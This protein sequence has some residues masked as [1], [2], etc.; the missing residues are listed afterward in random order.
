MLDQHPIPRA[1]AAAVCLDSFIALRHQRR[2]QQED[3]Q[4]SRSGFRK[5]KDRR[6]G[7]EGSTCTRKGAGGIPGWTDAAE[8]HEAGEGE[9][10]IQPVSGIQLG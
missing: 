6:K 1:S 10:Q 2:V 4:R 7:S 3:P 8:Y 5:G 9:G